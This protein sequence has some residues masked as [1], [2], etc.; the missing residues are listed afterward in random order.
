M[1]QSVYILC[2]DDMYVAKVSFIWQFNLLK[3][4]IVRDDRIGILETSLPPQQ[5]KG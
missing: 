5:G 2:F 3:H 1:K 4:K